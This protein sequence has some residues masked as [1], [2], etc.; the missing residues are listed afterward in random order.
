[1]K[2]QKIRLHLLL[3]AST[4]VLAFGVSP[5]KAQLLTYEGFNYS[6]N[7]NL[8]ALNGGS[9]WA[10]AWD[11]QND[12]TQY[13][14]SST[15]PLTYG[16]LQTTA[17][18]VYGGNT[19]ETTGRIVATSSGSVWANAGRVSDPFSLQQ[20]DQGV[21]WGSFLLRRD[22]DVPN[23]NY[24]DVAFHRGGIPWANDSSNESLRIRA[25]GSQ[26]EA[27]SYN[28]GNLANIATSALGDTLLFVIKWELSLTAG[29]NNIYLWVNPNQSTL[30]GAD[31]A[32][33][34]A[35][36][37]ATGLNTEEAR[38][39]SFK[40]YSG[41]TASA[42]SLDEIRFGTDYASVTPIPE[43]STYALIG[44]GLAALFTLRRFSSKSS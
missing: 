26:F 27:M 38:W 19:F 17:N 18:Y 37:S 20:L 44:L 36:W 10:A 11:S 35:T 32:T 5:V 23:W 22:A 34:T 16:T 14:V 31:L 6:P 41:N 12:N 4:A 13:Q 42:T 1:M 29:Q 24:L 2:T 3:L 28:N 21:V 30:G 33:N 39:R 40:F 9:G 8:D 7:Q 15:A 43:P 25:V